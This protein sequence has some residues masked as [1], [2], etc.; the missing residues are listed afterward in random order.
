MNYYLGRQQLREAGA[1][2]T[3]PN[4]NPRSTGF[5]TALIAG[6]RFGG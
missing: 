4:G 3:G 2:I 1:K 5:R 6:L